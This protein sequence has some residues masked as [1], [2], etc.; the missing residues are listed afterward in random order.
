MWQLRFNAGKCSVLQLGKNNKHFQYEM[1]STNLASSDI[2]KDLGIQVDA[3][4]K[5]SKHVESQ[6]NKANRILGLIKRSFIHL[7]SSTIKLLFTALV[8]PHL[9]FSCSAWHIST[10]KDHRLV[11]GVLRRATKLVPSLRSKSYEER[12]AHT[13]L[14]SMTHRRIRGDMIETYKYMH[15]SYNVSSSLFQKVD[16]LNPTRGHNFKIIKPRVHTSVRQ[17]FFSQ[18]VIDR[19]NNLPKHTAEAKDLNT[20]KNC[21]DRLVRNSKFST[22]A[23]PVKHKLG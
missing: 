22:V 21:Y 8:R 13:D 10:Q 15:G 20:F 17:T 2:E 9:E 14:P 23:P 1:C 18:R 4:L 3:N 12:L 19:W 6:V 11:E 16:S 5:F 7:D